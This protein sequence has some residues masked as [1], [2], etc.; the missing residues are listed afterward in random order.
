VAPRTLLAPCILALAL[1]P[2][3]LAGGSGSSGDFSGRYKAAEM[4]DR[5]T[6]EF[7]IANQVNVWLGPPGAKDSLVHLCIYAIS[8]D[9]RVITTDEPMGVPMHLKIAGETLTD[10]AVVYRKK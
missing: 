9:K 10:G 7:Q 6:L 2:L 8:D 5:V 1:V 4:G 3:W